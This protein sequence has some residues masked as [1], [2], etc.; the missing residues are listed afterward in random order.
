MDKRLSKTASPAR[1]KRPISLSQFV[2]RWQQDD[3]DSSAAYEVRIKAA[4]PV[5]TG[6]D[7]HDGERFRIS[8]ISWDGEALSFSAF[9]PSTK[10]RTW[11]RLTLLRPGLVRHELTTVERWKRV[12]S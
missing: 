7:Q 9:M 4:K 3:G 2:G 10:W 11:H 6:I 8:G 5:V 1:R 12:T